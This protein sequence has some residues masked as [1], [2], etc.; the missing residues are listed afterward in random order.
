MNN[1]AYNLLGINKHCP[2]CGERHSF[3]KFSV[4]VEDDCSD[5][6]PPVA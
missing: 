2:V 4:I 6:W 3:A 1:S 5:D